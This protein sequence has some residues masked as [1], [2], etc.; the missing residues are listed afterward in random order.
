[1]EDGTVLIFGGLNEKDKLV[2]GDFFGLSFD[3]GIYMYIL[4]V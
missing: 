1:M 3:E 2:F 4:Y